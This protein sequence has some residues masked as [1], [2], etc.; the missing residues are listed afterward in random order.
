MLQ[1]CHKLLWYVCF[2]HNVPNSLLAWAMF[3]LT[4]LHCWIALHIGSFISHRV[5]NVDS[6]YYSRSDVSQLYTCCKLCI[7]LN[8]VYNVLCECNE[9]EYIVDHVETYLF[10]GHD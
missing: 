8:T 2:L 1:H 3:M 9:A 4:G 7:G 5:C 10:H 6:E